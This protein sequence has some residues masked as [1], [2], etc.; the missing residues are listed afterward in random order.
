[1][2]QWSEGGRVVLGDKQCIHVY[3]SGSLLQSSEIGRVRQCL[4]RGGNTL[5][6]PDS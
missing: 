3:K 2:H 5:V 1:M 6:A 4:L